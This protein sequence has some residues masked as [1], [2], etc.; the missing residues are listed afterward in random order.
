MPS[1]SEVV[2]EALKRAEQTRRASDAV[3]ADADAARGEGAQGGGGGSGA[4]VPTPRATPSGETTP[5]PETRA[6]TASITDGLATLAS[7]VGS[8]PD[9]AALRPRRGTVTPDPDAAAVVRD[10][11]DMGGLRRQV[12]AMPSV[13]A[14]QRA[15]MQARLQEARVTVTNEHVARVLESVQQRF[16]DLQLS[17]QD[18]GT[19]GFASDRDI[20]VRATPR[21]PAAYAAMSD[22]QRQAVDRQMVQASAEAI[23]LLY[24][25][26]EA[27]GLPA[28]RALDTNF[29]TELHESRIRPTDAAESVRIVADQEIV[30]MTEVLLNVSPDQWRAY[31][32]GQRQMIERI[33]GMPD[34]DR[35]ALRQRFDDQ[36]TAAETN[37]RRLLGDLPGAQGHGQS[38]D[39]ALTAARDRLV[40]AM[41]RDPPPTAQETR[42]LMADVKLLEPDAY[43]TRGA[44]EGVV[45]GTQ[46]M[47]T[48][49]LEQVRQDGFRTRRQ[50]ERGEGEPGPLRLDPE[51]GQMVELSAEHELQR[52]RGEAMPHVGRV[53]PGA[54]SGYEINARSLAE[55]Q[56]VL[57]HLLGHLP[58]PADASYGSASTAA[59]NLGR[60]ASV[61]E[62]AGIPGSRG[63]GLSH[64][65]AIVAAKQA[66]EPAAPT[67]D[68]IRGWARESDVTGWAGREGVPLRTDSEQ[69]A[70]FIRWSQ[71]EALRLVGAMRTRTGTAAVH[72]DVAV[73]SG[74]TARPAPGD[75]GPTRPGDGPPP[76]VADDSAPT[77]DNTTP[78]P[79]PGRGGETD[80]TTPRPQPGRG[81]ETDDTTPR[82]QPG[83]EGEVGG[84]RRPPT[85]DEI[86]DLDDPANQHL[87]DQMVGMLP[88]H[89]QLDRRESELFF[90]GFVAAHPHL[91]SSLLHNDET[92]R[93]LVVQGNA[94][95]S[96]YTELEARLRELLPADEIG[97]GR[98][99]VE[100]H[101]HPID[102]ATGTTPT[103]GRAASLDDIAGAAQEAAARNGPATETIRIQT[104]RG[105]EDI[106]FGFDPNAEKPISIDM[107]RPDGGREPHRFATI[108]DYADWY[109]TRF[110]RDPGPIPPAY[111][112]PRR[113]VPG[114]RSAPTTDV[115]DTG[116][117]VMLR[118]SR[119]EFVRQEFFAE[120]SAADHP[121]NARYHAH[122]RLAADGTMT[123]DFNL[124]EM[125]GEE[126][127]R[128]GALRGSQ[129]FA[130]A[131]AHFRGTIGPD[132]VRRIR[133]EWGLGDNLESFQVRH[134][135]LVAAGM[136]DADA[137]L[138]AAAE[139]STGQWATDAGF[140]RIVDV[141]VNEEGVTATFERGA[142]NKPAVPDANG[143]ERAGDS[144]DA[145][146]GRRRSRD[147]PR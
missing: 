35:T 52:R 31:V 24:V 20:T 47:K 44:V 136:S 63:G 143:R 50:I 138:V 115:V 53:R 56:A 59:K 79:Q 137:R 139:T 15:A 90:D 14:P 13:T 9:P 68:A 94:N 145:R 32:D 147:T 58:A 99:S 146:R 130:D 6:P 36:V 112:G 84:R 89:L 60:I 51:S 34:P 46:G 8:N 77:T 19:P 88:D 55:A 125:R 43:G 73:G 126:M 140:G 104:E 133:G 17:V 82:P 85:D 30:S 11:A 66:P 29:Y 39:A 109:R 87:T 131:L 142:S 21:D 16:P 12:E 118:S 135:E 132:A 69:L 76:P 2:A 33:A 106:H 97:R 127:H 100:V 113:T 70:A 4:R 114:D 134:R 37:A 40:A 71:S 28:Q 102:P 93:S 23:P 111:T 108:E 91:E 3:V 65:G 72:D 64:L 124:R 48:A 119:D 10:A 144:S 75:Q 105:P 49:S 116:G 1:E 7:R 78:R 22:G 122:S 54:P 80:N 121:F 26:L 67:R 5:G 25:L 45:L 103:T 38:R 86:V 96:S 42:Q 123:M 27:A 92:G 117:E 74:S 120:D 61:A 62:D 18:L 95:R 57:A 98:W 81:G 101:N 128:S 41:Q 110:G 83:R 141:T 129:Q 107:P